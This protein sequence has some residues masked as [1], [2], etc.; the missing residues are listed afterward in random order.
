MIHVCPLS[1]LHDTVT[2][3]GARHVVTLLDDKTPVE[4]PN[5][6]AAENHLWLRL[7]DISSPLDGYILPGEPHV[8]ELLSFVRSWDRRAPMVV[9]CFAGISRSTAS[10]YAAICALNPHR[11]EVSVAQ[12][13]RQASPTAT[14]N[15]RIV[16][17]ADRLLGRDGRM[18]AAVAAIGRGETADEAV[19]F[20]LRLE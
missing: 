1:R 13:L 17:L 2:V 5:A 10:A 15:A 18:I 19:P 20:E 7:H 11:H 14:P 6:V 3:T 4:R 16:A 8:A 9:H 12:A